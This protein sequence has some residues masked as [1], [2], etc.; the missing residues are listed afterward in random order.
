VSALPV[1]SDTG[2]FGGNSN[3]ADRSGCRSTASSS[4]P[5]YTI[6]AT[7]LWLYYGYYGDDF[8]VECPTGSRRRMTLYQV[9]T[10]LSRRLTNIIV[11][12]KDGRRP[13]YGGNR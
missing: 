7:I 2:M 5:C 12:T 6:M 4:A 1:E 9:A 8:T 10:E 3:L 11:R 13:V